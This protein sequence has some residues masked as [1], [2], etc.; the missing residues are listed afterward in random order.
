M[1]R[2]SKNMEN[3]PIDDRLIDDN[4]FVITTSPYWCAGI[5]EFFT[6]QQ[7]SKDWIKEERIKVRVNSW[8]FAVIGHR[9]FRRG[10]D[11]LLRR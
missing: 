2:L 7:L 5:M 9:L 11:G 8:H 1:S 6:T 3:N 4:L 10:V